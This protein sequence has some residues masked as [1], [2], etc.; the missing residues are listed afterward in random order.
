MSPY[1][2]YIFTFPCGKVFFYSDKGLKSLDKMAKQSPLFKKYSNR[3]KAVNTVRTNLSVP[4][5]S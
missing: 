5:N 2:N 1:K 4:V 3:L